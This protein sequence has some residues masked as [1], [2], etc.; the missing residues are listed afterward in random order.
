MGPLGAFGAPVCDPAPGLAFIL[1][2]CVGVTVRRA[3]WDQN[4]WVSRAVSPTEASRSDALPVPQGAHTQLAHGALSTQGTNACHQDSSTEAPQL[5]PNCFS[6]PSS[7]SL[8][9]GI[10]NELQQS[11]EV[12]G[13]AGKCLRGSSDCRMGQGGRPHLQKSSPLRVAS[14]PV[15]LP[16]P[17]AALKALSGLLDCPSTVLS[18]TL[19]LQ[20]LPTAG[21]ALQHG[22]RPR[23]VLPPGPGRAGDASSSRELAEGI[24]ASCRLVSPVASRGTRR[25]LQ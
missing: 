24:L 13:S 12:P 14:E 7:S 21:V 20:P 11:P 3:G 2:R 23:G 17:Q 25:G 8:T 10:K 5:L 9:P 19:G 22:R 1:G 4:T 18:P 16:G 15:P 6:T